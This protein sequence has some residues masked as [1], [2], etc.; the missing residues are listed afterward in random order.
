MPRHQYT[1]EFR[2]KA[3]K[4]LLMEGLSVKWR[5]PAGALTEKPMA[6]ASLAVNPFSDTQHDGPRQLRSRHEKA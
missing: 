4:M 3:V 2:N 5:P 1:A 6:Y